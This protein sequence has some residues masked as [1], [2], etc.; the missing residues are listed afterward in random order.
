MQE[1]QELSPPQYLWAIGS[2][3]AYFVQYQVNSA[4]ILKILGHILIVWKPKF[5]EYPTIVQFPELKDKKRT[6]DNTQS[7]V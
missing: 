3:P 7:I 1:I 6:T 2:S 5:I 4:A